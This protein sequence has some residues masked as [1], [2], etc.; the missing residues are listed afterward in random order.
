M[1]GRMGKIKVEKIIIKDY[2]IEVKYSISKDLQYFFN[3]DNNFKIIYSE[4]ISTVPENIAIIPFICNVLPIIWLSDSKLYIDIIDENF[5]NILDDLRKSFND[6]NN[7][8]VFKGKIYIKK[9]IKTPKYIDLNSNSCFFSGGVDSLQTLSYLLK[10]NIDPLLITVW[11]TDVWDYNEAGWHSLENTANLYGEFYGL[12]NLYI[13]SN[14]RKFINESLLTD[15]LL[16][17]KINDSW[18]HGIQH[19]IGLLGHIAPYAFIYDIKTHYIPGTLKQGDNY[20]CA[21]RKETDEVL[22]ISDTIIIHEGSEYSR[23]EKVINIIDFF[24]KRKKYLPFRVC[25]MDKESKLNCCNCEKCFRTI[26]ELI[27]INENPKKWGFNVNS[28]CKKNLI[29]YYQ[30]NIVSGILKD[31]YYDIKKNLQMNKK[32]IKLKYRWANKI[33]FNIKE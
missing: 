27:S 2:S 8:N 6:I 22:K 12:K 21:S 19:G 25:Y 24:K 1:V 18:W 14:F 13:K 9:K 10:Q 17:G 33:N 23:L 5:A 20:T 30:E 26:L 31:F 32:K 7:T 4:N 29:K 16:I 15:K 28:L 3:L 11:G